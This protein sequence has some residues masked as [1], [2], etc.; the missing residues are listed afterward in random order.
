[1]S[2]NFL[3]VSSNRPTPVRRFY[4]N[5]RFEFWESNIAGRLGLGVALRYAMGLGLQPIEERSR[6]LAHCLRERL[7]SEPRV[8]VTDLG[9]RENQC[10]IVSFTVVGVNADA[11][12]QSL[13]TQGVYVAT[14][15]AGSTPLDARDRNLPTVVSFPLDG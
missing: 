15:R 7:A 5:D 3:R 11:I 12:K 14:S 13:R 2:Q 8:T 4:F 6:Y 1:M 9:R 10:G